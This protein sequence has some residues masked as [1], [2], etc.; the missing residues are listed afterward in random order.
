MLVASV[1]WYYMTL[2]R[3]EEHDLA[4]SMIEP[5]NANLQ[6]IEN[7]SYL[8]LIFLFKGMTGPETLLGTD[9]DALTNATLG[10]GVGNWYFMNGQEETA[11]QIWQQVYDAGNWAS[12]GYIAAEAELAKRGV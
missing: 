5:T 4:E 12:F 1:Y 10:Y 8:D 11:Y 2:K 6:M 9:R 7:E 3:L